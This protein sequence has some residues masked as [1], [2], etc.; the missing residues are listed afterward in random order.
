MVPKIC[1]KH[2]ELGKCGKI[3][4]SGKTI[5]GSQESSCLEGEK[6]LEEAQGDLWGAST[7]VFP[8]PGVGTWVCAVCEHAGGCSGCG[9]FSMCIFD[10]IGGLWKNGSGKNC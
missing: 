5:P 10:F 4:A 7:V 9:S 6:G 3:I 1:L 2:K 8:D